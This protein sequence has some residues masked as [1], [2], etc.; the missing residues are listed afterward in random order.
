VEPIIKRSTRIMPTA[1]ITGGT[2]GLG[3]ALVDHLTSEGWTVVFD[4]RRA[5]DVESTVVAL[6][7]GRIGDPIGVPGDITEAAHRHELVAALGGR[8]LDLLVNNAGS[9]GPTPLPR[10][11]DLGTSDL[12]DILA[13]N[14]VATLAV[15][16]AV[17]DRLER[18]RGV[19]VN[20]TSDAAVEGYGGWGGYGASKAALDQISKVLSVEHPDL[21][22]YSFDP[23]DMRTDMHQAAFPGE[24]ITDR[25][26]PQ[27]IVPSL[28]RL[29][30]QRPPSGRYAAAEISTRP[31]LR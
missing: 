9:L 16:Q 7:D 8:G 10:L 24:D 21:R 22:I 31:V 6:R 20:I 26:S 5:R 27:A 11:I 18:T 2:R 25:P 19:V 17:A 30:E 28:M 23:G 3:R 1:L 4:A 13:A 15:F 14:T 29:L 12:E